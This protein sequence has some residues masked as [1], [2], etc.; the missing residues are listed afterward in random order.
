MEGAWQ[1]VKADVDQANAQYPGH[2]QQLREAAANKAEDRVVT[3]QASLD[4]LQGRLDSLE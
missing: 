2:L 4:E 3:A 1:S